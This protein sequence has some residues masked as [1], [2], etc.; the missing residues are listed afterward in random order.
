MPAVLFLLHVINR[1]F[2]FFMAFLQ[3]GFATSH[4]EM[5]K[6]KVSFKSSGLLLRLYSAGTLASIFGVRE[7]GYHFRDLRAARP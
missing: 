7:F 3:L 5:L 1:C 4:P 6:L 2:L